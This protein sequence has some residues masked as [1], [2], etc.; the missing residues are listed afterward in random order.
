MGLLLCWS[1]ET[2]KLSL[3]KE[4]MEEEEEEGEINGVDANKKNNDEGRRM[5]R[6]SRTCVPVVGCWSS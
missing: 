4:G 2:F 6:N 5:R 1:N 3:W